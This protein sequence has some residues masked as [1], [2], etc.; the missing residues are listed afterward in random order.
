AP[1]RRDLLRSCLHDVA[2]WTALG[3][4]GPSPEDTSSVTPSGSGAITCSRRRQRGH[5]TRHMP[6][7]RAGRRPPG[8]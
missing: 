4:S 6:A 1:R 7:G 2:S 3:R 5:G 8:A